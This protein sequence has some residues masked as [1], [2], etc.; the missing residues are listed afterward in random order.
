MTR[1]VRSFTGACLCGE[2]ALTVQ[3]EPDRVGLCHCTDCRR[4]SGS[5]FTFYGVWPIAR[6]AHAGPTSEFRGQRFC[7]RCGSRL[8][9]ADDR[10]AE[11]KLG[12]LSEAPTSLVPTYE[13][14]VRRREP[15]LRPVPGAEQ[16][17]EDRHTRSGIDATDRSG[18]P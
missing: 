9:A 6:F 13:L 12:V 14:W 15:W 18:R 4:E 2:V 5:A 3:G 17:A 11:V 8:F 16:H 10:E 1:P 7:A